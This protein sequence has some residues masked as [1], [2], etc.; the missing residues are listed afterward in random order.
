M[1]SL[2]CVE[3]SSKVSNGIRWLRWIVTYPVNKVIQFSNNCGQL[4]I[5]NHSR[6]V[7][8]GSIVKP[9]QLVVRAGQEPRTSGFQVRRPNHSAMQPGSRGP[10]TY[11]RSEYRVAR[12]LR[13]QKNKQPLAPRVLGHVASI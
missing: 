1:N 12:S 2:A 9:P 10:L 8:F 5:Y 11:C 3:I 13:S 4:A 6:G 7:E